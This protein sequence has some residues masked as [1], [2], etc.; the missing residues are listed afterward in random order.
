MQNSNSSVIIEPDKLRIDFVGMAFGLAIG[1]IGLE[2]GKLYDAGIRLRDHWYLGTH[3]LLSIYIIASSWIGWQLSPSQGNKDKLKDSFSIQFVILLIDLLLVICYF[4]I[5]QSIGK[6]PLR[7]SC[8]TQIFWSKIIFIV[9]IIWDFFSKCFVEDPVSCKS[10]FINNK[11]DLKK[12]LNRVYQAPIC[13]VIIWFIIS[14]ISEDHRAN[15]VLCADLLLIFVF[16][17]FRGLKGFDRTPSKVFLYVFL[18]SILL[19]ITYV[20]YKLFV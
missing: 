19:I 10:K 18:P 14:P 8:S 15:A 5:V 16:V 17:L 20:V 9:Y 2:I 6:D 12:Y 4:I 1:E 11:P 3:I 7:P 13:L